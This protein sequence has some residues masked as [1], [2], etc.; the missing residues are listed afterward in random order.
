MSGKTLK[1]VLPI[2]VLVLAVVAAYL[3]ASS[4]RAPKRVERPPLGP[5]VEV[6][7]VESAD[8]QVVIQGHG[9]VAAKVAVDV[10]PQVSGRVVATHASLV[11]GGFFSAGEVLVV[12]DPRDYE[13]AVER[14]RASVARA[15]VSLE[16]ERAEAAVAR[17]EWD[18]LHP[19]E[20]APG[21]VVREPQIRQAE[22]E[23]DAANA[24]LA[25]ATLTWNAP[26]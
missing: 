16:R 9:E 6:A 23:L 1:I 26:R 15:E 18:D 2:V 13:L 11:A 4:R 8:V 21:L 25:A 17:E 19:G 3:V 14:A 24:D 22:A 7:P 20:D 10:I 5:L 12:I